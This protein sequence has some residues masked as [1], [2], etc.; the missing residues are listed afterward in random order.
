MGPQIHE[1]AILFIKRIPFEFGFCVEKCSKI[2]KLDNSGPIGGPPNMSKT[3]H[4]M[5][6][7]I[8]ELAIFFIKQTL[9]NLDFVQ[10]MIKMFSNWS[11][12]GRL[13]DPLFFKTADNMGP[14]ILMKEVSNYIAGH[15][16]RRGA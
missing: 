15:K 7:Q 10:C 9:F 11:I 13:A 4:K 8:H 3:A 5:G 6:P 14:Q 12:L 1:L 16:Y 2:L